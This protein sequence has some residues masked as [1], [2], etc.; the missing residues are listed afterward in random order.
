MG[1]NIESNY[2][3][4]LQSVGSEDCVLKIGKVELPVT[5]WL[6][7]S[8]LLDKAFNKYGYLLRCNV[9]D[10]DDAGYRRMNIKV[11]VNKDLERCKVFKIF[12]EDNTYFEIDLLDIMK[13]YRTMFDSNER[14]YL[15]LSK[16]YKM[17]LNLDIFLRCYDR[18]HGVVIVSLLVK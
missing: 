7:D 15:R 10:S 2:K 6:I 14:N 18:S 9:T 3:F 16:I 5:C 1:S 13:L 17:P 12:E 4:N 11:L 8:D